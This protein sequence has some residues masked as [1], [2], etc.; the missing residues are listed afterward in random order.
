[1][2]TEVVYFLREDNLEVD[3]VFQMLDR[4]ALDRVELLDRAVEPC[5]RIDAGLPEAGAD[6]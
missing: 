3:P 1:M 2:L 6:R 5:D 4:G